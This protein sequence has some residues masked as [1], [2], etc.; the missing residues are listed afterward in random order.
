MGCIYSELL[1]SSP[2]A[3]LN[4]LLVGVDLDYGIYEVSASEAW[5]CTP[6]AAKNMAF[7]GLFAVKG[8]MIKLADLK[9]IDL[10][11]VPLKA[12]LA[13]FSKVY[14]L[15]MEGVLATKVCV[16][17]FACFVCFVCFCL[18]MHACILALCAVFLLF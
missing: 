6:R 9:G 7:Q 3:S 17:L 14:T 1:I 4:I 11:G 8:E 2:P 5:I 18:V 15:P 16:G 13:A 10:I 12:P